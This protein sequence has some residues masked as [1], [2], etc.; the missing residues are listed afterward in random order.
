[1]SQQELDLMLMQLKENLRGENLEHLESALAD[2]S[3]S[4]T[5]AEL[6][7]VR[8]RYIGR[9]SWLNQ[10]IKE[11]GQRRKKEREILQVISNVE[12]AFKEKEQS[13]AR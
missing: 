1:M 6:D 5:E 4:E 8:I 9:K 2:I 3:A 7:R 11:E 13:L 12:N 10:K